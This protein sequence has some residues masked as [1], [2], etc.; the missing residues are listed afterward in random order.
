LRTFFVGIWLLCSLCA[1]CQDSTQTSVPVF[2]SSTE[3]V[4]VPAV[5]LD[6]SG[7]HI[8]NLTK[9]QF[10]LLDDK[11]V[12]KIALFEKI[13]PTDRKSRR[14][15]DGVFA[16]YIP[17]NE[18][19]RLEIFVLDM[20]NTPYV[21]QAEARK[22]LLKLLSDVV[23]DG[24]PKS[25]VLFTDSGIRVLHDFTTDPEALARVL[26]RLVS[27]PSAPGIPIDS[28]SDRLFQRLSGFAQVTR[29]LHGDEFHQTIVR[30]STTKCLREIAAAFAG[31]PGRKALL[32]V[33]AG[34]PFLIQEPGAAG[35]FLPD[36]EPTWR[37]LNAANVALY[38]IDI[39]DMA[40]PGFDDATKRLNTEGARW[41]PPPSMYSSQALP[42]QEQN[43]ATM[44][45]FARATG[46]RA[47]IRRVDVSNC[48]REALEDSRSYYLLGFYLDH[49]TAKS[50]WHKLQVKV[51]IKGATVRARSG[52]NFAKENSKSDLKTELDSAVTSPLDYTDVPIAAKLIP[53][54][55][56]DTAKATA[57][58]ELFLPPGSVQLDE[59][60][61]NRLD[62]EIVAAL[63]NPTGDATVVADRGVT[64]HLDSNAASKIKR[65]GF[66]YIE[67]LDIPR[68]E[69]NV[70][71]LVRDNLTGKIGSVSMSLA[72][73]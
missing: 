47:C 6:R 25:L 66:A 69:H 50:G 37:L 21:G 46:G 64:S 59:A 53:P 52:F 23:D 9:E 68:G 45:N 38:P 55:P 13:E 48:F 40:V 70:R 20:V 22:V 42:P 51:N 72:T 11:D 54:T 8:E 56:N 28:T 35:Y 30:T 31:V 15:E 24:Q 19:S 14:H 7:K 12:R 3:L 41:S 49:S 36:Y 60:D 73:P 44:V 10:T 65:E 27:G 5:I 4:L 16:N 62:L 67:T 61:S 1:F 39:R 2:R 43:T 34:F 26:R 32:W 71:L 57:K 33:T 29:N 58:I 18:P 17:A 63:R